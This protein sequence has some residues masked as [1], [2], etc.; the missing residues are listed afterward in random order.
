MSANN[1]AS[2][3]E[4]YISIRSRLLAV[5][6]DVSRTKTV[7][8]SSP[9]SGEGK[10]T[11]AINMAIAFSQ[12]GK[13]V[14]LIDADMRH[15]ALLKR[16]RLSSMFGL[17]DLLEGRCTLDQAITSAGGTLEVIS[18]GKAVYDPEKL[19]SSEEYENLIS[20]VRLAYDYI[21]VDSPAICDFNDTLYTSKNSD[22]VVLV[23]REGVSTYK[24]IDAALHHLSSSNIPVLG[25]VLNGAKNNK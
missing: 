11:T 25:T 16:M 13:R 8:V 14:L 22:G 23:L 5:F 4:S 9:S 17:S 2:I 10:T 19:L 3:V 12:L 1:S 24:K 6:G 7:V 18:S 20:G 21:F 15:G